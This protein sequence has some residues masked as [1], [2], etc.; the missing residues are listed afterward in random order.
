MDEII[1]KTFEGVCSDTFEYLTTPG[2]VRCYRKG[3]HLFRDRETTPYVFVILSGKASLYKIG[4]N[5]QKK[6]AFILGPGELINEDIHPETTSSVSCEAFENLEALCIE[7][8]ELREWMKKDFGLTE[9]VLNAANRKVRRLYR[10][11]KNTTGVLKVERRVAAKLWKL[12]NDYGVDSPYGR[13]IDLDISITY[14]AD[15][16]GSPRETISRALKL[17]NTQKLIRQDKGR[18]TVVDMNAL[19]DY[20][21]Q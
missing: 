2:K 9:I 6:V 21:K 19:S 11:L 20:F 7:K 5:G 1:V 18:I 3:D 10:Q 8:A 13:T 15:L 16:M 17:L 4:E 12:A 14:L